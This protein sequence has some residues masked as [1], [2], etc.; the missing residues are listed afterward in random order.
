MLSVNPVTILLVMIV[1]KKK[2]RVRREKENT[3]NFSTEIITLQ[4]FMA[5]RKGVISEP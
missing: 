2:W 3:M 5:Y 4:C 1:E